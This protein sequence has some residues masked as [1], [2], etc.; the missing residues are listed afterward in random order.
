MFLYHVFKRNSHLQNTFLSKSDKDLLKNHPFVFRGWCFQHEVITKCAL[1]VQKKNSISKGL[2]QTK[3]SRFN[4]IKLSYFPN[5]HKIY[6]WLNFL[7]CIKV[8]FMQMDL[9]F[10]TSCGLPRETC[11]IFFTYALI[12][13]LQ[14]DLTLHNTT[15]NKLLWCE[16]FFPSSMPN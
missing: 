9:P 16:I 3:W 10:R 12:V 6:L 1:H 2:A 7:N 11:F 5:N 15:R 8:F 13:S 14:L 4:N